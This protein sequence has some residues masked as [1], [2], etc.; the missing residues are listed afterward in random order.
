MDWPER[1]ERRVRLLAACRD[2]LVRWDWAHSPMAPGQSPWVVSGRRLATSDL[3]AA[4][5]GY[6][7]LHS[8]HMQSREGNP[9]EITPAG[10]AKL[11]E[12]TR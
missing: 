7:S 2:G 11:R 3:D 4:E 1:T 6:L 5:L 9:Q 12:W 8:L 10:E